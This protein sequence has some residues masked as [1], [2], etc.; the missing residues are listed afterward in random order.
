[1]AP[2]AIS[3][4]YFNRFELKQTAITASVN[5]IINGERPSAIHGSIIFGLNLTFSF[6][7]RSTDFSDVKNRITQIQETAWDK[8]VASAAPLTPILNPKI[9]IGSKIMLI[10][11]PIATVYILVLAKPCV[12]IKA[13]IPSVICTNMVPSA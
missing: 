7:I 8:I 6:L 4:P 2:T 9:R 3:P 13:F 5:C 10:M 11:A 12:E 1:M